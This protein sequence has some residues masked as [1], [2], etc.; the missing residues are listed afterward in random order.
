MGSHEPVVEIPQYLGESQKA[1]QNSYN[2]KR[3]SEL[4][5]SEDMVM[6]WNRSLPWKKLE[7]TERGKKENDPEA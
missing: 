5:Q 3:F 2:L 4:N 1:Y 7:K 6:E